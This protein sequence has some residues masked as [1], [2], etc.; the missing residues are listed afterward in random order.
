METKTLIENYIKLISKE[1]FTNEDSN[2]YFKNIGTQIQEVFY[3]APD[4]R[5]IK[6]IKSDNIEGRSVNLFAIVNYSTF[7]HFEK[8][9]VLSNYIQEMIENRKIELTKEIVCIDAIETLKYLIE[10][11]GYNCQDIIY[12]FPYNRGYSFSYIEY[13]SENEYNFKHIEQ[14][15]FI[16]VSEKSTDKTKKIIIKSDEFIKLNEDNILEYI[17]KKLNDKN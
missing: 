17:T 5:C 7:K 10:K 13:P 4:Q 8:A 12:D 15:D 11:Q 1:G 16:T 2:I 6:Q 14:T 3:D 9:E